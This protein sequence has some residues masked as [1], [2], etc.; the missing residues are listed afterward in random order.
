MRSNGRQKTG[1]ASLLCAGLLFLGH[2]AAALDLDLPPGAELVQSVSASPG[3]LVLAT[4]PWTG[5]GVPTRTAEGRVQEFIWQ[6]ADADLT[7][8]AMLADLRA[9]LEAQGFGIDFNCFAEACGGFDFRH[10]LPV[11]QPPE[12][13]VD[14][15]DYYYL[16]ATADRETGAEVAALMISR[17][18]ATGFV[19][20]AVVR[21]DDTVAAPVVNSSRAPEV[22]EVTSD[23]P[24]GEPADLIS[25]LTARGAAPLDDLRFEVGASE[26]SGERYA[27]LSALAGFLAE[28]PAVHVVLVGHTDAVGSLSSNITLSQARAQAVLRFLTGELGVDPDQ[29]DA[30]GIGFLSPRASNATAE[31]RET[32]RRV[33]VVLADA[34]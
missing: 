21:P 24:A 1:G 13:Y 17:G 5:D 16:T 33:E 10:A 3:Q 25:V 11:G 14:L 31:G 4:G 15:S 30:E 20:L 2:G 19:H 18:G 6:I 9:Q 28:N 22:G 7:T 27:S 8:A 32:N 12:M 23:D 26:L 29:V 34:D